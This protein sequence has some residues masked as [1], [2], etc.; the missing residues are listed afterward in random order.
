[1]SAAVVGLLCRTSDRSAGGARGVETLAPLV[2]KRLG[3]EPRLIGTP[4]EPRE[5][6]FEEDLRDSRGC[7]LEA[8]GQV[9]DALTGANTPVV[10]AG[11]CSVCMTT[12][13]AALRER[14][15]AKVL[16]LDAHG[17]FNTPESTPS[18][19]LGGMAL[20]GACGLW[21]TGL[22]EPISPGS[23]VLA[24]VRDLDPDERVLLE[25]SD[26]IVIGA[27]VLETL[28]AVKNALDGAPVYV[29]LDVDVLDP[30]GAPVQDPVSG[31]LAADKL[32]DVLEAVVEDSELV[33]F[34][35][36]AFDMPDD[37]DE[38]DRAAD[39]VMHVI[40]PLLAA[41]PEEAHVH[42]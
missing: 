9:E 30:E 40:E 32:F 8:G 24:G 12:L 34:E 2:G 42:D 22:A 1:M 17:D 3:R 37:P 11:D 41:V 6:R 33:G 31:G 20:A 29:H 23:V 26:A 14:P 39:L 4:G 36:T 10:L 35:V 16:W 25:R 5:A 18:G 21:E 28:V 13:P 19:F 15:E 27:S 38:R 7:L